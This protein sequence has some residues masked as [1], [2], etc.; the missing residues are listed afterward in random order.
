MDFSD[1]LLFFL[2]MPKLFYYA[3]QVTF[4]CTKFLAVTDMVFDHIKPRHWQL[5]YMITHSAILGSY[6][7]PNS[8]GENSRWSRLNYSLF[9]SGIYVKVVLSLMVNIRKSPSTVE[10]NLWR[11]TYPKISPRAESHILQVWDICSAFEG[12]GSSCASIWPALSA[13]HFQIL[14]MVA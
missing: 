13:I 11:R 5:R 12:V 7:T 6:S 10:A 2:L 14:Y 3:L 8:D 1:G 4:R 9:P